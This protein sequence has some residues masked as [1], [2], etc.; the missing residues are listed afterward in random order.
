MRFLSFDLAACCGFWPNSTGY[1][2]VADFRRS[3]RVKTAAR[4]QNTALGWLLQRGN[5]SDL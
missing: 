5:L 4:R 2:T 1:P 3:A